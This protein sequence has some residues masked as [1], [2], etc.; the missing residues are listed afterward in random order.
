MTLNIA[1]SCGIYLDK[2]EYLFSH[3]FSI[4]LFCTQVVGVQDTEGVQY[5]DTSMGLGI[6]YYITWFISNLQL[7]TFSFSDT[8][9]PVVLKIMHHGKEK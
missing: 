7:H 8:D 9:I 3:W 5:I 2:K 6:E 4:N 1:V